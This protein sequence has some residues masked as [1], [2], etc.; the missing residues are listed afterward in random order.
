VLK[1]IQP[2]FNNVTDVYFRI[3]ISTKQTNL[4]GGK[5]F[6]KCDVTVQTEW[7]TYVHIPL[8]CFLSKQHIIIHKSLKHELEKWGVAGGDF[9][10]QAGRMQQTK[11]YFTGL[12]ALVHNMQEGKLWTQMLAQKQ[13]KRESLGKPGR[14]YISLHAAESFLRNWQFLSY[15]G[16]SLHFVEP[17]GSLACLQQ[18]EECSPWPSILILHNIILPSV[19]MSSK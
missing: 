2:I 10:A 11:R 14:S 4:W 16:N 13:N 3:L 6:C 5:P 19:A 9:T 15:S 8:L 18:R 7:K 1:S 17:E 12:L